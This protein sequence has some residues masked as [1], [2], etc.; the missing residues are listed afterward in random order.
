MFTLFSYLSLS[1]VFIHF[2]T[3]ELEFMTISS[4]I[5]PVILYI[6]VNVCCRE[7]DIEEI[8]YFIPDL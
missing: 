4:C 3:N 5:F 6:K 7:L 1:Y 2:P 8:L